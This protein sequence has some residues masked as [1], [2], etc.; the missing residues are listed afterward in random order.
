MI[1]GMWMT[2]HPVVIAPDTRLAGAA[3]LMVD[4]RIR[5][6]PVTYHR[7]DG[8]Q[9]LGII[10]RTDIYRAVPPGCNPFS[11]LSQMRDSHQPVRELMSRTVL[12]TTPDTPIEDAAEVMRDRKIG[13][14][15]VLREER[16]G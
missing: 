9:L 6:L 12:T 15:P 10:S 16:L 13:A 5:R 14:L 2:R 8:M 11:D 3:Q 7:G 4:N 1:V